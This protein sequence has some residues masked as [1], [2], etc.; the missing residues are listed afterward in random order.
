MSESALK[1]S[2]QEFF[3]SKFNTTPRLFFSPGRINFIGEHVD[4]NDG[5]VMPAAIDKGIV[6]AIAPNNSNMLR[7]HSIDM[8][9]YYEV[10]LDKIEK[11]PGWQN[12]VLGVIDQFQQSGLPV[13]GMDVAFG[14]DLPTGAG[15]S[16]SAAVECGL[17]FG[18]S[19]IFN[20]PMPRVQVAL[21]GQ[22]AEHTFPGVQCGIMDQFANMMGKKGHVL[23]LDCNSLNYQALPLQLD[24]Y[25]IMLVNSKVHHSLA[26]GEYNVRRKQCEEGWSIL[27]KHYLHAKTFRDISPDQVKQLED[28]FDADVY[29]RCLY[30]T[31]E[32]QR[33]QIAAELLKQNKLQEF[34]Q[35]MFATHWGL[36][37]LYDVSCP[38]LDYLVTEATK[39]P[40]I[41]G[42]R[43][44]GGG[45]GG[46]TINIVEKDSAAQIADE[47]KA[48]Y[49]KAFNIDTEVYIMQTEDGTHEI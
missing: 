34:G 17:A 43:L 35:L 45:F 10:A 14:G 23:L 31:E 15:L 39:Y 49:K 24:N 46:C 41:L 42:S 19:T 30:V 11:H 36:S 2:V 9:D 4:Y 28:H 1:S 27:Q 32:I 7:I 21:L 37:R 47:I 3:I 6:F 20:I 25:V 38:E 16:S 33:T 26:S 48:N 29:R 18:I 5:F 8:N 12:Y 40:Q 22:K 44:M 13:N